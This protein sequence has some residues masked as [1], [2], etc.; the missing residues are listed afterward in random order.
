[1]SNAQA[2]HIYEK[3]GF[4]SEGIRP[5]F[6][7]KPKEDALILWKRDGAAPETDI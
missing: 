5:H 6:Y 4:V 1:M 2:I 7:D 3:A